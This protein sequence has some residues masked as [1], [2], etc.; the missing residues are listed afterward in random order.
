MRKISEMFIRNVVLANS[1]MRDKADILDL[2]IETQYI[3]EEMCLSFF[4]FQ[5]IVNRKIQVS[6]N[7]TEPFLK[8]YISRLNS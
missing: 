2:T 7:A 6:R 4:I 1:E 5:S 3:I 8:S